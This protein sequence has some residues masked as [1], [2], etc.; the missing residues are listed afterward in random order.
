MSTITLY[1]PLTQIEQRLFAV[2]DDLLLRLAEDDVSVPEPVRQAALSDDH[3]LEQITV[4]REAL[5]DDFSIVSEVIEPLVEPPAF[6]KTL[7]AHKVAA[8]C[9]D[10]GRIPASGQFIQLMNIPTPPGMVSDLQLATPLVVLLDYQVKDSGVWLGWLVSPEVQYAGFWDLLLQPEDEPFDPLCGM[11][12]IWNPIQLYLP[13]AFKAKALGRL[14]AARMLSVRALAWEYLQGDPVMPRSRPGFIAMRPT[15]NDFSIVTGSPLGQESDPR[16]AYQHCYHHVADLLNEPVRV[17]QAEPVAS[18]VS[19][20]EALFDVIATAW[21]QATGWF[22]APEIPVAHAM[23]DYTNEEVITM[24]L[25]DDLQMIL[26]QADN[27]IDVSLVYRGSRSLD[28]IVIDDNEQTSSTTLNAAS[29]SMDYRGLV[30]HA[31]NRLLIEWDD[32]RKISLPVTVN[33]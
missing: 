11:V 1:P 5:K 23:G 27:T 24:S 13:D 29:P 32:G 20:L 21:H 18:D 30:P 4:L 12:Q 19:L 6:I 9:A 15:A 25:Q 8:N 17:W 7:I 22:P 10:F 14:S 31:D 16:H 26:R 2:P 33:L 28:I 3:V